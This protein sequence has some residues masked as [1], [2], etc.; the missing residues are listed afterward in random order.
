MKAIEFGQLDID[1]DEVRF[2]SR[3]VLHHIAEI[4]DPMDVIGPL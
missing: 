2:H 3:E 1:N 4:T